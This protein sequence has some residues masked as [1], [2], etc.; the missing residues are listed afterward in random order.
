ML[1]RGF[2]VVTL[3]AAVAAVAAS[4]EKLAPTPP[5][6][7]NSWDAYGLTINEEQCRANAQVL[8]G[9]KSY[10]WNYAVVDEGWYFADAQARPEARKSFR[11]ANG[12]LIPRSEEHTSELQS[13][14]NLVCRLLLEQK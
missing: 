3:C 14:C 6:G 5:M 13:P 12:R 10:G 11:D 7:W 1:I 9:L 4:A 8:V 2:K